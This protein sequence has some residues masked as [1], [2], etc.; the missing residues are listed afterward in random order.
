[1][2]DLPPEEAAAAPAPINEQPMEDNDQEDSDPNC[3]WVQENNKK[4]KKQRS[5][6]NEVQRQEAANSIRPGCT[7][8]VLKTWEPAHFKPQLKQLHNAM[9][10]R[11]ITPLPSWGLQKCAD[12]LHAKEP[13]ALGD[14]EVSIIGESQPVVV[15]AELVDEASQPA[16][17]QRWYA[18]RQ[19]C[20]LIHTILDMKE[21]FLIRDVGHQS[22]NEKESA[23]RNSFWVRAA[24]RFND[25][26]FVP[27]LVKSSEPYTNSIF[28]QYSLD[29]TSTKYK[30][31]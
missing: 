3:D 2:F 21:E 5:T 25:D 15:Q 11:N 31:V 8:W 23:A 29:P 26:T 24:T 12:V 7:Q 22:R 4:N 16:S 1:M 20:R 9:L 6:T 17:A 27:K 30:G 14:V 13:I 18:I 28:E 10:A 19:G